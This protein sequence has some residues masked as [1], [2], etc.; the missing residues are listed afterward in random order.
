MGNVTVDAMG[1][2]SPW[3][4]F[5]EA[6]IV[7]KAVMLLLLAASIWSWALMFERGR[8]LA[9]IG[10]RVRQFEKRFWKAKALDE[11]K[12][13]KDGNPAA[14]LFEAAMGEWRAS[15]DG[16]KTVD[17]DGVR[18]R[19]ETVMDASIEESVA[20]LSERVSWLA[21]I[22]SV[23]PFVGLFGTVWG[24]MRAFIG[25]GVMQDT[26]L[27]VVAPGIA[28]ALFATAM[29]LFAAIPA[30]IG[31]NHILQRINRIEGRLQTFASA[32]HAM[33]SRELDSNGGR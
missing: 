24:I 32:F 4:L 15:V 26:S 28:E 9:R 27:A 3:T 29:G 10:V 12:A 13:P 19:L 22:G 1:A 14:A 5:L 20:D 31:Y 25:I 2:M 18:G 16:R 8:R 21:T 7:V 33:M 11:L 6:D 30:V 23:S 17:R